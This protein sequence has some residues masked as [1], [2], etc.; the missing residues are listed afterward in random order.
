MVANETAKDTRTA[1]VRILH[2]AEHPSVL[3]VPIAPNP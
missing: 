3:D 1:H 2:D